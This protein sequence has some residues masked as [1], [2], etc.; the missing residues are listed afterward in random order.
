MD[1]SINPLLVI[2][3]VLTWLF[4]LLLIATGSQKEAKP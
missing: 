2:L 1:Q 4:T 3:L